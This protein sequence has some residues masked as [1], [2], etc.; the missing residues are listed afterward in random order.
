MESNLLEMAKSTSALC[1]WN[2]L[3]EFCN[4]SISILDSLRLISDQSGLLIPDW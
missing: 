1:E 3:W 4:E 2:A